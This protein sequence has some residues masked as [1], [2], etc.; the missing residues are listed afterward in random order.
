MARLKVAT[1]VLSRVATVVH[2]LDKAAMVVLHKVNMANSRVAMVNSKVAMVVNKVVNK[3]ATAV[4]VLLSKGDTLPNRVVVILLSRVAV[5]AMVHLPHQ[6][7]RNGPGECGTE[8]TL[9]KGPLLV[10]LSWD[11]EGLYVGLGEYVKGNQTTSYP[12]A[13]PHSYIRSC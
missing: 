2:L 3:V 13:W 11:N 12:M 1:A 5:V 8:T 4:S 6:D 9:G 7:T 10:S